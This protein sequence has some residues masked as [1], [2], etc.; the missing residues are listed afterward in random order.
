MT[1]QIPPQTPVTPTTPS[2]ATPP[3]APQ[4]ELIDIELFSKIKLRIATILSVE[5]VP[6]SKKLY[7]LQVDLGSL[8]QRQ[9]LSGIAQHY[10]PEQLVNR[11]VVVIANLKTAKLMGLESQGMI[12]AAS[13]EGDGVLAVLQPDKPITSGSTVR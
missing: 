7:K 4:E 8:G 10:P 11:Q 5:A 6:K 2:V 1:D 3:A 12:L 13:T 9:I